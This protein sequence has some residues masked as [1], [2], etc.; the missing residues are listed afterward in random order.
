MRIQYNN[1]CQMCIT[2]PATQ[3]KIIIM[4]FSFRGTVFF[5][6]LKKFF[7]QGLSPDPM[8]LLDYRMGVFLLTPRRA[9]KEGGQRL[10]CLFVGIT[11]PRC[12]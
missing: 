5:R 12:F 4:I 9:T 3:H 7:F 6:D 10:A 1:T 11:C 2:G 8:I